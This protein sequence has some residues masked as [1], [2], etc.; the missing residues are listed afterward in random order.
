[1]IGGVAAANILMLAATYVT[2]GFDRQELGWQLEIVNRQFNLARENNFG[3]WYSSMLLLTVATAM[4]LCFAQDRRAGAHPGERWTDRL[5]PYGWLLL[6]IMFAGLSL[7]ELG[8]LHERLDQIAFRG[9]VGVLSV[10]ILLVGIL[11]LAFGWYRVRESRNA[12]ALM[13]V[14]VLLYLTLPAQEY[15]EIVQEYNAGP[16]DVF[17]RSRGLVLL[18][19]GTE[20]FGSLAFLASALVFARMRVA[21]TPGAA[22]EH[23][24]ILH[25]RTVHLAMLALAVG[26][27][28]LFVHVTLPLVF[29]FDDAR[30]IPHNWLPSAAAAF[31][32]AF[33][34]FLARAEHSSGRAGAAAVGLLLI[35]AISFAL[36]ID[37]ATNYLYTEW[38]FTG[39]PALAIARDLAFVLGMVVAVALIWASTR[40]PLF[41]AAGAAWA[42]LLTAVL[43][44][45][46]GMR[47]LVPVAAWLVL[48]FGLVALLPRHSSMRDAGSRPATPPEARSRA[49]RR[50]SPG[51]HSASP[52]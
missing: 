20:V 44:G 8:S 48:L 9:W 17:Q 27:A 35:A 29:T 4:L 33:C 11:M 31:V 51:R 24:V 14:G 30:G 40:Q 28:L 52:G 45:N 16:G 6:A 10:P 5:L 3:A 34:L 18:E 42:T 2:L 15:Y 1:M 32:G 50:R 41:A 37:H 7:D 38:P 19:E 13:S 46:G 36:S 39:R 23:E 25:V 43:L 12:F 22:Q 47:T 21:E 49:A 26:L